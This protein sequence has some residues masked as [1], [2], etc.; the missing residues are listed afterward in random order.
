MSKQENHLSRENDE[1]IILWKKGRLK[2][3]HLLYPSLK[4]KIITT[5]FQELILH[6]IDKY[7]NVMSIGF[8]IMLSKKSWK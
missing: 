4:M 2:G 7:Q 6:V 3:K 5:L 8:H 1:K